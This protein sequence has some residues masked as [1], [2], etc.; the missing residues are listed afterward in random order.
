MKKI[1]LLV[2]V[3]VL[4][5]YTHAMGQDEFD[6]AFAQAMQ[7]GAGLN[8]DDMRALPH[9]PLTT[10]QAIQEWGSPTRQGV[11]QTP[12]GTLILY[13]YDLNRTVQGVP[14]ILH[15]RLAFWPDGTSTRS[16]KGFREPL[17]ESSPPPLQLPPEEIAQESPPPLQFAAPP[18]VVVVPSEQSDVYLVPGTVGLYFYGDSWYRFYGGYWFSASLYSGPWITIQEAIVPAAVVVIPP[19]YILHMPPG[20]YRIRYADFHS[21]WRDW[22]RTHYWNS[23][24]WYRNHASNHWGGIAFNRTVVERKSVKP[25]VKQGPVPPRIQ[26]QAEKPQVQKQVQKPQPQVQKP[27]PQVQKQVQKPQP[28]VQKPQVQKQVQKPQVQKQ[29]EQEEQRK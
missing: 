14:V 11:K 22:G 26:Q 17:A 24:P 21:H 7:A 18:D 29:K 5:G 9:I 15:V 10:N 23:Q 28:K 1:L 13:D 8:Q 27:Q 19:D 16:I 6:R 25:S 2:M 4:F 20:Y 12:R 3:L